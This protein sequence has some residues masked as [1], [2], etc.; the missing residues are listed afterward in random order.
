MPAVGASASS[1]LG[2]QRTSATQ[3]ALTHPRSQTPPR[4]PS[5]WPHPAPGLGLTPRLLAP[6]ALPSPTHPGAGFL[7]GLAAPPCQAL[8]PARREPRSS[9]RSR[10]LPPAP[11][12]HPAALHPTSLGPAALRPPPSHVGE[13]NVP[14]TRCRARRPRLP[15]QQAL[16]PSPGLAAATAGRP[17]A[18]QPPLPSPPPPPTSLGSPPS[19]S[20]LG[21]RFSNQRA[22]TAAVAGCHFD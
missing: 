17:R 12:L 20:F 11:G 14:D 7:H 4:P 21:P 1:L 8:G 16:S 6:S 22:E 2:Q 10:L 5:R 15:P 19:A 13:R 18:P 3:P 9:A